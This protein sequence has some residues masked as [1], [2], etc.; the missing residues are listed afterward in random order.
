MVLGLGLD[1]VTCVCDLEKDMPYTGWIL[2]RYLEDTLWTRLLRLRGFRT[3]GY[4]KGLQ[5]SR[6]NSAIRRLLSVCRMRHW[7]ADIAFVYHSR[8]TC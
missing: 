4:S 6:Y 1:S 8:D 7:G 5:G 3:L 2:W